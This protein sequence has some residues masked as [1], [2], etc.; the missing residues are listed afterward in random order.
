MDRI[1]RSLELGTNIE[2]IASR[3]IRMRKELALAQ[4]DNRERLRLAETSTR[5]ERSLAKLTS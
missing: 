1:S 4:G 5:N 3:M 2:L